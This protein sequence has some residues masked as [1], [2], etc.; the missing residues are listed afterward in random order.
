MINYSDLDVKVVKYLW[1]Y[2]C[3]LS[4]YSLASRCSLVSRGGGAAAGHLV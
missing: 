1:V 4:F 3:V 2:V